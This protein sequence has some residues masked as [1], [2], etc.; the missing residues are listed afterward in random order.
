M[1]YIAH[2]GF[3]QQIIK[4]NSIEAFHAALNNGY[5][6]ETDIRDYNSELVISHD[7]PTNNA[8][9]FTD[10]LTLHKKIDCAAYLAL[11]IKADGLRTKLQTALTDYDIKNYFVFDMSIP[12]TYLYAKDGISFFS[13]LSEFEK[14]PCFYEK[15]QGIWL[16]C[17]TKIWYKPELIAQYLS[18]GKKVCI[19]SPELHKRPYHDFW[20]VLKSSVD[21][22]NASIM[23]CTDCPQEAKE[24][25]DA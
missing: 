22:S 14:T 20:Q 1:Q 12:E 17:F 9:L 25:F 21:C 19:V 5:G 13:R 24:F 15:S 3:W 7:I 4:K 2:R 23:L 11:N 6:I 18:E 16:D 10:F 8:M